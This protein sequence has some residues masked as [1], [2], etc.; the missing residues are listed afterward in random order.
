MNPENNST[1]YSNSPISNVLF[2]ILLLTI[3]LVP[4]TRLHAAPLQ[5]FLLFYSNNTQG[6]TEPC[7]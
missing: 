1:C 2:F 7:G 5:S 3:L 4:A 6:E